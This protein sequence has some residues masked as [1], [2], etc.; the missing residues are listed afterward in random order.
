MFNFDLIQIE[1]RWPVWVDQV[2]SARMRSPMSRRQMDWNHD[3]TFGSFI[4]KLEALGPL[5]DADRDAIR[6]LPF[7]RRTVAAQAYLVREGVASSEC[8]VLL[9]GY[10]CR[11]KTL[12]NGSRQI[13]SFHLPGD[14]LDVQ[15]LVLPVADHNLQTITPSVVASIPIGDVRRIVRDHQTV[16]LALW[17]D[18]LIDASIFR[19]WVLNVG[20][21]DAK[22]RISHLLCEFAVRVATAGLGKPEKFHLPMTQEVIADATGL[23]SIHVNRVMALLRSDGLLSQQGKAVRIDD[24]PGL[25]AAADF[26]PLYLHVAA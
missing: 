5:D 2:M 20:R 17:R 15:Q 18:S 12:S 1:A 19:E 24:W 25:R 11:N 7:R 13:V 22:A 3:D 10:A 23:T 26:D 6:N 9:E 14:M 4:R 21:R 8:S 16:A